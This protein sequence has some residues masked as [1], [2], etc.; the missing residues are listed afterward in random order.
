MIQDKR[1]IRQKPDLEAFYASIQASKDKLF[2][3]ARQEGNKPKKTWYVVQVDWDETVMKEAKS[4]GR[5][6]VRW[7]IR[8]HEDCKKKVVSKCRFWPEIHE[9][10][11]QDVLGAMKPMRPSKCIESVL[12]RR[13]LF[14]YQ[15]KINLFA[16]YIVGP[17]NFFTDGKETHHIHPSI[18]N[19]LRSKADPAEVDVLTIDRKVPLPQWKR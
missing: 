16:D 17:F 4:F 1:A 7:Y 8:Q 10:K 6:H 12:A 3:V 2:V 9:M 15:R 18:W 19:E 14:W 11:T 13:D 5:Y